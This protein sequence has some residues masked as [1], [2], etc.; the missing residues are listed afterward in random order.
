MRTLCFVCILCF[1]ATQLSSQVSLGKKPL[2]GFEERITENF[3]FLHIVD[4]H[5]HLL[6]PEELKRW[7]ILIP[8]WEPSSNTANNRLRNH[9]ICN[10]RVYDKEMNV[11]SIT[12]L[13]TY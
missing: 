6:S 7:K 9:G 4:T 5:E 12:I 3:D 13:T 10:W 11:I 1:L 8:Y 2:P